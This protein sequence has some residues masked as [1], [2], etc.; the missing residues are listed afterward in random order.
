[1][2]KASAEGCFEEDP[3][4]EFCFP[5]LADIPG[6]NSFICKNKVVSD[7]ASGQ[8]QI[9]NISEFVGRTI[10]AAATELCLCSVETATDAF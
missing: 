7:F 5:D 2:H 9:I 8:G 10:S 1:M 3:W 4:F 6:F